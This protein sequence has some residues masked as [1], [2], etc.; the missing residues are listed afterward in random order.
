MEV[1]RRDDVEYYRRESGGRGLGSVQID[2]K[3]QSVGRG[4]LPRVGRL[5]MRGAGIRLTKINKGIRFKS[6]M[7]VTVS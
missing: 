5:V 6:H 1:T 3:A 4:Y 2:G 7:L